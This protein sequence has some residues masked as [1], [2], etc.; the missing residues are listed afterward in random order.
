METEAAGG[1]LTRSRSPEPLYLL[2]AATSIAVAAATSAPAPATAPTSRVE[3]VLPTEAD[4]L[5]PALAKRLR[6]AVMRARELEEE[7]AT[8]KRK[9]EYLQGKLT[10]AEAKLLR[11]DA[12]ST[13]AATQTANEQIAQAIK[14]HHLAIGMTMEQANEALGAT[15]KLIGEEE[16]GLRMYEWRGEAVQRDPETNSVRRVQIQGTFGWF[17][18]GILERWND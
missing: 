14:L 1:N 16:R 6:E 9:N 5:Y 15:G 10:T 18:N 3:I 8:L 7:N 4:K 17:R 12:N 2:L 13:V 11:R